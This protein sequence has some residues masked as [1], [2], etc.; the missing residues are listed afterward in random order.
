MDT[1]NRRA[2]LVFGSILVVAGVLFLFGQMFDFL[3]WGGMWPLINIGIGVLFFVAMFLG[4]K[5]TGPLAIPGAIF[6]AIGLITF[7]QNLTGAWGTWAYAWG[8]I[9]ASVGA[10]L[11]IYGSWSD[12]PGA[13][14]AGLNVGKVGLILFLVFGFIFEV[15]FTIFGSSPTGGTVFF[16]IAFA[17]VGLVLLVVRT[18]RLIRSPEQVSGDGR[19][20]FWPVLMIGI[21]SLWTLV[22]LGW[23]SMSQAVSVLSLWPVL[24]IAVGLDIITGRRYPWVGA[25]MGVVVVAGMFIFAFYGSQQ[26]WTQRMNWA[27]FGI[28]LNQEL[29]SGEIV[30]GSGTMTTEERQVSGFNRV[31]FSGFG[32]M[33]ISQGETESLVITADDNLLPLITTQVRAGELEIGLKPGVRMLPVGTIHYQLVVKDLERLVVSGAGKVN[34]AALNTDQL[35]ITNSGASGINLDNLQTSRLEAVLSGT[36]SITADG[37]ADYLDVNISGAGGFNAADLHSQQA[38]VHIS[39]LGSATVWVDEQLDASISGAGSINYYGNPVVKQKIT[40]LGSI[41]KQGDK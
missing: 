40:G 2:A 15:I 12:R 19:D 1:T 36:G 13:K 11:Y 20:L 16:P 26:G 34:V 37:T 3:D 9:V 6:T 5:T 14:E 25:L 24:L 39:G 38:V 32:D 22:L 18:V 33:E 8:L 10:G 21:G 17:G 7:V 29:S 23:L 35:K 31:V 30:K 28:N 4:G 27:N 41:R